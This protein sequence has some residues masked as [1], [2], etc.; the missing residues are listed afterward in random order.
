[1]VDEALKN[2]FSA[3]LVGGLK[4]DD[5]AESKIN[6]AKICRAYFKTYF[7]DNIFYDQYAVFYDL[8]VN[9]GIKVCTESILEGI[10][11]KNEDIILKSPKVDL[12]K[13]DSFDVSL[14]DSEKVEVFLGEMIEMLDEFSQLEVTE[15][16]F[17]S[18]CIV[19]RESFKADYCLETSQLMTRILSSKGLE[20]RESG[21]RAVFYKGVEDSMLF[22]AE[23]ST[24]IKGLSEEYRLKET[25][26]NAE[27]VNREEE[28]DEKGEFEEKLFRLNIPGVNDY[29]KW[30][31]RGNMI[32]IMGPAKAGKT[33]TSTAIVCEAL[34]QGLNVCIWPIEGSSTEWLA[35]M[36]SNYIF[37]NYNVRIPSGEI[38]NK[39]YLEDKEKR[40]LVSAARLDL[41]NSQ[42][43]GRLSFIEGVAW[44]EDFIENMET[45]YNNKNPYDL[46]V[47]DSPVNMLSK[48]NKPKTQ[49]ISEGFMR[50]KNYVSNQMK[51]PAAML[52]TAQIK[53]TVVDELRKNPEM[54]LDITA[55]GESAET[56]RTPDEVIGVYSSK[57]E[58][59]S[60]LTNIQHVASRHGD[61]FPSN[62]LKFDYA[63]CKFLGTEED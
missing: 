37:S 30:V 53:Q 35:C 57:D 43:L 46:I 6:T 13:L 63:V 34:E 47:L 26:I 23:R 11:D 27:W 56:I 48:N 45:H 8:L 52:V 51:V 61:S 59:K 40:R 24:I 31:R 7:P 32:S 4:R 42:R 22:Y 12:S 25:C 38:L 55:G 58:R 49:T 41:A 33:R 14:T 1:M 9:L 5:Q 28:K 2:I 21:S 19:Y 60:G 15:D 29:I 20:Y 50:A 16:E 3:I 62:I 39:E 17:K 18:S 54:E 44:L 36:T 10:I